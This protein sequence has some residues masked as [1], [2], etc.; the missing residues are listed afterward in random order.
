VFRGIFDDGAC[1]FFFFVRSHIAFFR[2]GFWIQAVEDE[3][4]FV[5]NVKVPELPA[6]VVDGWWCSSLGYLSKHV[7]GRG[8]WKCVSSL[9]SWRTKVWRGR[10]LEVGKTVGRQVKLSSTQ[11]VRHVILESTQLYSR[12]LYR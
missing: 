6:S 10:S 12:L 1:F 3:D 5:M 9:D 8:E 2:V 4:G 7:I 11:H